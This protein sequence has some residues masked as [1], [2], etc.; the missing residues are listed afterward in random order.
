MPNFAS[1]N[2]SGVR[3]PAAKDCQSAENG[4]AEAAAGIAAAAVAAP[5]RKLR[6]VVISFSGKSLAEPLI[7]RLSF[8]GSVN[9]EAG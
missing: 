6:R 7:R 5:A 4:P 2:Q 3:Y 8:D 9:I 1:R